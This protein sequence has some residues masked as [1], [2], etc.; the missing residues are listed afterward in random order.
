MRLC[1]WGASNNQG[2]AFAT[3]ATPRDSRNTLIM[4]ILLFFATDKRVSPFILMI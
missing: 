4:R 1:G 3:C 2:V